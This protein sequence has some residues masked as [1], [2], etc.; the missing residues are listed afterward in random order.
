MKPGGFINLIH[1]EVH[2]YLNLGS[3]SI[4]FKTYYTDLLRVL[5]RH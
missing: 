3:N 2:F 5:D 4:L 1:Y